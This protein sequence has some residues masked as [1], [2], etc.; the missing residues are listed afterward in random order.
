MYLG[1]LTVSPEIQAQGIGKKLLFASEEFAK[2]NKCDAM[3]MTVI[4]VRS[5]LIAWY[6]RHGYHDTG[7]RS[8]FEAGALSK[9]LQPLE[10]IYM[11]KKL[12]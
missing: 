6:Q 10:F 1:M 12:P 5:E 2:Q 11:E 4:S 9:Q 8:P 3:Q 7:K